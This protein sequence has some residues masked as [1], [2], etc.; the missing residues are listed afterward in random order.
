MATH[1]RPWIVL[2]SADGM[3]Y[4]LQNLKGL[5]A[6]IRETLILAIREGAL[7]SITAGFPTTAPVYVME[8]L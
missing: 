5:N 3:G 1:Q 4:W 8:P 6:G 7:L 2:Q